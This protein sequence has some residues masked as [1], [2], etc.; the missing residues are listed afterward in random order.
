MKKKKWQSRIKKEIG[1]L[2]QET[3]EQ[4]KRGGRPSGKRSIGSGGASRYRCWKSALL[5]W[6]RLRISRPPFK[7]S[8]QGKEVSS[9]MKRVSGK[10]NF[11]CLWGRPS[12]IER[13]FC[14][15]RR[16]GYVTSGGLTRAGKFPEKAKVYPKLKKAFKLSRKELRGAA[17]QEP[18][19]YA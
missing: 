16:A 5:P 6:K 12:D 11:C 1:C 9:T 18:F 8:N 17:Y 10:K 19:F 14:R 4:R 7:V 3:L 2:S 15:A 13:F